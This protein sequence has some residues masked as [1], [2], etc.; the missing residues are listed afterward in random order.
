MFVSRLQ[1]SNF[2]N[3]AQASVA[4]APGANVFAGANGQGKTNL[5][6][7][8]AYLA[9]LG[10]HRVAV[11][12]PLVKLGEDQAIVRADVVR[13]L[14]DERTLLVEVEINPHAA[15]RA[16]LNK[17]PQRRVRDI[18]GALQVVV[19]TPEDLELVKGDPAA[20]RDYI[21]WVVISRWPRMAGVKA[22]YERVLKQRNALLKQLALNTNGRSLGAED[23]YTLDVW[24][25]QLA[26]YGTELTSARLDTLEALAPHIQQAYADI[27]P[28][29]SRTSAVYSKS[30]TGDGLLEAL[31]G[32]RPQELRRGLTLAGPHRDEID[33]RI[34]EFPAK[35]FASHGESWSLAL[36]LKLAVFQLLRAEAVDPVLILDDVFAELDV[37]RRTRLAAAIADA[38]QVLITAAVDDDVPEALHGKRLRVVAGV[39]TSEDGETVGEP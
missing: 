32:M 15:N 18:I 31:Q 33:L 24:D 7:A 36:A 30:W 17:V 25:E 6:E 9:T 14:T 23:V 8:L 21:D 28:A 39:V 2:R 34:G 35:G 19:F 11:D 13:S 4:L 37:T 29:D 20:R 26:A 16:R 38:E 10:S 1:L 27:A 22:D 5:V 3:Y 12:A